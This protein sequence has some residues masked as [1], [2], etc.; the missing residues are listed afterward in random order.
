MIELYCGTPGSGKSASM[1]VELVYHLL[2]GGVVATNFRLT[3]H[4]AEDIVKWRYKRARKDQE[5]CLKKARELWLRT[6]YVGTAD[7]VKLLSKA[8]KRGDGKGLEKFCSPKMAKRRE[9]MGRLFIDEAQLYFNSRTWRDNMGFI[10]FFTQHRKLRWDVVLVA[11]AED[12]IDGQIRNLVEMVSCYRALHNVKM[13]GFRPWRLFPPIFWSVQT[14]QGRGP[15]HG[16]RTSKMANFTLLNKAVASAY[17]S[18]EVFAFQKLTPRIGRQPSGNLYKC[19]K[20]AKKVE[21]ILKPKLVSESWP[22]YYQRIVPGGVN[23]GTVA[24]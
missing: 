6:F 9:G 19:R 3:E 12:M 23:G 5:Y 1:M 18:M 13:L 11:H 17:D 21:K 8:M 20:E 10:E 22:Q 14:M 7:S 15:G 16:S 4:W 24:L 2:S